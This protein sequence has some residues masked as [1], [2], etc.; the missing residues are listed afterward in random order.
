MI[1]RIRI[2]ARKPSEQI[3]APPVVLPDA[4]VQREHD[5]RYQLGLGD[6]APSFETRQFPHAVWWA[7]NHSTA[8]TTAGESGQ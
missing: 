7:G 4:I 3:I 2:P 8:T 6:D 1:T 5:G